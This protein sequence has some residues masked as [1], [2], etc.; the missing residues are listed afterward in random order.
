ILRGTVSQK[1]FVYYGLR[2][3]GGVW[4]A[5]QVEAKQQG[6]PGSSLLVIE[7][8]SGKAKL[9]RKDFDISQFNTQEEKGK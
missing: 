7:T 8:G 6:K 2:Q 5:M 1:E 3:V 4:T 9:G